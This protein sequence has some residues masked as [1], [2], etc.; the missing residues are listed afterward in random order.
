MEKLIMLKRLYNPPRPNKI[1]AIEDKK[2]QKKKPD[3]AVN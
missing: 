2:C 3:D 1:K